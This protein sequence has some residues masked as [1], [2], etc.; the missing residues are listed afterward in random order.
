M[1]RLKTDFSP[2]IFATERA[3]EA[4][5]LQRCQESHGLGG[6]Q[7]ISSVYFEVMDPD[8]FI[9]ILFCVFN[10]YTAEQESTGSL[11]QRMILERLGLK[12]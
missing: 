1:L 3:A 5:S 11:S 7:P 9:F 4:G 8:G 6:R 12:E 2:L 10:M